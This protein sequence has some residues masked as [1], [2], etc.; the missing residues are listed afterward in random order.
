MV[1]LKYLSNFWRTLEM[2]LI[3]CENELLLTW[4]RNCVIINTDINNQ[5]PAFTITETNLYVP[6]VTLSTQDNAKLLPQLKSGF[7]RTISWNKYLAKPELLAKNANLNH[8]IEPGFQG[9][10]S[11]FVLAF[12][13]EAQ[14]ISRKRYCIPNVEIIDCNVMIDGKNVFHQPMNK[15]NKTFENIRKITIGQGDDYT[16]GCLLDYSYF[17][18]Y[19]KMIAVDLSKQQVLDAD[20]KAIQQIN[21]TAN[22]T[23][24]SNTRIYFI[25]EEAKEAIFEF[26]QGTVKVL[27]MRFY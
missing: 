22:L 17:K 14:R 19:Y 20:P 5:I 25:L 2:P 3:N 11:L 26:S 4:S 23:R 21:F 6:V 7:K 13:D 12:E 16:A 1:P 15:M 24:D 9:V 10:N 8:L 18:K 27:Q